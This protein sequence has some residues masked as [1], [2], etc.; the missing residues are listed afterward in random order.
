LRPL[1]KPAFGGRALINSQAST[2]NKKPAFGGRA[3]INSQ[4]S[5]TNKKPAYTSF[6][7]TLFTF[8]L[9]ASLWWQRGLCS[10]QFIEVN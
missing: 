1:N 6:I 4:A 7:F 8:L 2:T 9:C 10:F 5:T 3:L